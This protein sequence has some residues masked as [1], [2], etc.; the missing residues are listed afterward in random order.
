MGKMNGVRLGWGFATK[1][2]PIN[3]DVPDKTTIKWFMQS[4]TIMNYQLR[5]TDLVKYVYNCI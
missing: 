2:L 3:S 5:S 4:Q 1:L